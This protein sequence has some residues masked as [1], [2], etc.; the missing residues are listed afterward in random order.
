VLPNGSAGGPVFTSGGAIIGL[1]SIDDE[2]SGRKRDNSR[3][4][5]VG[6]VCD[7]V[8]SAEKKMKGATPPAGVHLPVEM[9]VPPPLDALKDA[10]Q[11]RAGSLNPYQLAGTEFDVAFITPVMTF[12][13]EYLA[14]QASTRGRGRGSGPVEVPAIFDFS[15][16]SEYMA[17]FPP[18]LAVRATPKMVEG[19]WTK[20]ARGAAVTQGMALPAFKHFAAGF[21]RMQA[22]CGDTEVTPI[23]PFKLERRVSETDAIYEGFYLFDPNALGPSC[24]SVKLVLFSEKEPG[25]ADTHLVDPKLIER[26]AQDFAPYRAPK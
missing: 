14:E 16:W 7:V 4:V 25:K 17:D 8:A 10:A 20:V 3:V 2:N 6:E 5:R 18:V 9:E 13:T 21:L 1:T 11:R 24:P 12:G 15:N 19:F 26:I 22:F 23:H